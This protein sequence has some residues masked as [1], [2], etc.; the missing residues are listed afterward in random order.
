MGRRAQHSRSHVA[1][2]NYQSCYRGGYN[3]HQS[4]ISNL[5][6]L[7]QGKS[8]G[9]KAISKKADN[10][11]NKRN[12]PVDSFNLFFSHSLAFSRGSWPKSPC[13]KG[14]SYD[15]LSKMDLLLSR[16]TGCYWVF[17]WPVAGTKPELTWCSTLGAI[18]CT[19]FLLSWQKQW[20]V[21]SAINTF[22]KFGFIFFFT[23]WKQQKIKLPS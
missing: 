7:N 15:G 18:G 16:L 22:S 3:R 21:L 17:H 23:K 8:C 11:A 6:S 20:F 9:I 4:W 19:G 13:C 10:S 12:R 1:A 14:G 5:N 2:L